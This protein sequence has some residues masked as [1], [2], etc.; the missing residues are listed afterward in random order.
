MADWD[1]HEARRADALKR[2]R[3]SGIAISQYL[4]TT[5]GNPTETAEVEVTDDDRVIVRVG[6]QPMG[7][8]HDTSFMQI[9]SDKLGIDFESVVIDTSDSDNL[10]NGGGSHGSR[11]SHI[12]SVAALN[13]SDEVIVKGTLIASEILETASQDVEYADGAYR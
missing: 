5:A 10:P 4:E 1:S 12:G 9:I 11:T 7:Q 2:G 13:S 3:L 8:G 6:T